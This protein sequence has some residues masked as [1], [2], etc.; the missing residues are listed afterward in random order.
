ME[1]VDPAASLASVG[2]IL[3]TSDDRVAGRW[4]ARDASERPLLGAIAVPP[5]T[6]RLRVAALDTT[7]RPGAAEEA[8]RLVP[9]VD[10][11]H[12]PG[13]VEL[14]QRLLDHEDVSGV[15]INEQN[16]ERARGAVHWY[17][18]NVRA[19]RPASMSSKLATSRL[20]AIR[21]LILERCRRR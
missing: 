3:I 15:I 11:V 12:R 20:I 8:H 16:G 18:E 5:G 2:A 1:P 4:F 9:V 7:G 17:L 6:Y 14:F 13:G 10:D 21:P 19:P